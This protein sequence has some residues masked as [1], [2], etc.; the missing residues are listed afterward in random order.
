MNDGG[1]WVTAEQFRRLKLNPTVVDRWWARQPRAPTL[2][3]VA[4]ASMAL[5]VSKPRLVK[6]REQG[7]M[8]EPFAEL[9]GGPVY[10]AEEVAV[11]AGEIRDERTQREA[12]RAAKNGN[13]NGEG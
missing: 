11:L 8:P 10:L 9:S 13:G 2:M 1:R 12:K 3:G 4:E 7:R 5:G 6:L